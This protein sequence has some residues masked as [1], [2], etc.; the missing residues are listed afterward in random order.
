M[1]LLPKTL[2]ITQSG[3]T[4]DSLAKFS[5]K[6]V[7]GRT[8]RLKNGQSWSLVT[9]CFDVLVGQSTGRPLELNWSSLH[10]LKV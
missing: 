5:C 3:H 4:E 9:M 2:K 6:K 7:S 10:R 1:N 8:Q